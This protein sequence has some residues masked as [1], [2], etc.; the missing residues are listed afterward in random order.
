MECNMTDAAQGTRKTW[1]YSI[2]EVTTFDCTFEEDVEL[3]LAA[4]CAGIGV[5]GFKMERI[6]PDAANE[7]LKRRNLRAAN[8][9]P[10]LNSIMP[11]ALSPTP[12]DP[13]KRVEAFLPNME[14]MAKL[15]PETIV[16]ITGP[17]GDRSIEEA[18]DLCVKGFER[19]GQAANDL[20]VTVALEPIHK[21]ALN[22]LSLIWDLPGTLQ[23]LKQI[24]QPSF[25]ILFDTWHLWDTADIKTLLAENIDLI[26]GVH[27][28]DW[29]KDTRTWM[30]R[31]FPGEGRS[32][33]GD[34]V[35]A[36]D[37]AGFKGLYDVEIFSD[38]GQFSSKFPD[39]LWALPP[40]EIVRRA[41]NI[42]SE[43]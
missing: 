26:G 40:Q 29:R 18:T 43:I 28:A 2:S 34:F 8:C 38:N 15:E 4:G 7:L 25:K 9:I 32:H 31:A 16:V 33:V 20:G 13:M 1:R 22:D 30:D 17:R 5:W 21:S 39:S 11:Y 12:E 27:V 24:N 23:M 3:Y 37:N 41:T 10:E 14:R 42:F 35:T 19:I 36:L 6:G